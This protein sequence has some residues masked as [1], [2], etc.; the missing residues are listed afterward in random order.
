MY[1]KCIKVGAARRASVCELFEDNKKFCETIA[2]A[3]KAA[4]S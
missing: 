2:I 1:D 4:Q 3:L